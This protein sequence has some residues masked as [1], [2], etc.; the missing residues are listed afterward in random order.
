MTRYIFVTGGVV[1]S[2]GK[3][4]ASASLAAILEAR[5][6]K[7]TM[8]KLDPYINVDPG[9]MSPF[10]HGEVFVTDDGAET[11]LDLGHYERFIRTTMSKRNNF[12]T[13]RVYQHV[14]SK[15]RRGDYLG[16][17]VQVIPHITNEIKRRVI[18][19]AGDADVALVEIGGT[20]GDIE[21][22]PFLEAVR[23]LKVEV[24]ASRAMFMHLTLVPYI[25]TAGET[26]TKPTQH[27]VKEL[28]SI[29]IQPD[30]LVCRSEQPLDESSRKKVAM[31]TNVDER[32]VIS[33]PDADTIY[34]IP[35]MLWEQHLDEIVAERFRI[36]C[37]PADLSEWNRVADAFLN[38]E[39]EVTI[40]MVGKYMELLDAYKSLIEAISHAGIALRQKVKIDYID[41]ERVERE[42]SQILEGY[43]AILV[44]GGF[45][46]RGV[47][48]KIEA[49]RFARE[50]K[51]PYLGI[52][53]GMQVAVIEYAR[54]VAGFEGANSTEFDKQSAHP[55]IGLITE[56]TDRSG[57]VEVRGE[58]SD[59]GGTMR[60]GAQT[61]HLAEG[62]KVAEA[63]G[64]TEV[65]ERHRHR[66][67]VNNNY[68][69]LLEEAGLKIT[70]RSVD[71]ELVEVVEAP[72][73]PWFVA[74]Q[75]HPEFTSTPRDGHGL[76]TG[77]IKAALAR[78]AQQ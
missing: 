57:E 18:E 60:L 12:T 47:E 37:K 3:G 74:C 30:I 11:D 50:N 9:T 19:G 22:L 34:N 8:L 40:A 75:F 38:P 55:V 2:L 58:N 21:S 20:V 69:P 35:A 29:G 13:G 16:G 14:L 5:G 66:Y 43:S 77:F 26:K 27:S 44:P 23:Q 56:W 1:S 65:R 71:G 64:S 52:C 28:R 67:E 24:G 62:S 31:F 25:A 36:S 49:V 61:C 4:I 72:D 41:S 46:E 68:V 10:Q 70:G 48:G 42:G 76:F 15:E 17:T 53:L 45:G 51:V 32:A 6:L 78:Q 7:V 39:G 63:Y 59:L 33:L 54:H 73:H